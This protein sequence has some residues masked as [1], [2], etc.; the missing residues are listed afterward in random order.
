[1]DIRE[2][3]KRRCSAM[4]RV[5]VWETMQTPSDP[6]ARLKADAD[7]ALAIDIWMKAEKEFQDAIQGM[8]SEELEKIAI[9]Q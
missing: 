3:N 8:T 4:M 9:G 2:L 7:L 5:R 1:M 6:D